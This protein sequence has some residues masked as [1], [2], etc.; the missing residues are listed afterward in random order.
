[1]T[2]WHILGAGSIGCLFALHL[3][4][5]GKQVVLVAKDRTDAARLA[6]AMPLAGHHLPVCCPEDHPAIDNLLITLKSWQTENA[7]RVLENCVASNATLVLLQN[8]MANREFLRQQFPDRA[9]YAAITTEAACRSGTL[10]V[11]H[12]GHG[13]TLLGAISAKT[14]ETILEKLRSALPV[15]LH[16]DI[17]AASWQKLVV[18]CCINPLSVLFDCRNGELALLP[19]AQ[20]R[21]TEVIAECRAVAGAE[22]MGDELHDIE[23]VV[24]NVIRSTAANS[25][26]M[27]EDVHHQRPTEIASMNGYI[28]TRGEQHGIATPANRYLLAEIS[29]YHPATHRTGAL[30]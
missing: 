9:I 26:S 5:A 23:T 20:Q 17:R 12:T 13:N 16:P 8:G 25:S 1:M 6:A 10:R 27:R 3:H 7:L 14:D 22:G 18:N 4:L 19:E 21:I 15:T 11:E 30:P 2:R 24:A 28:V 29:R